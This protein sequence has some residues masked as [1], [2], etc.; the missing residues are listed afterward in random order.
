MTS[1]NRSDAAKKAAEYY[2]QQ[3]ANCPET[4][5]FNYGKIAENI[6]KGISNSLERLVMFTA[7][8]EWKVYK[9]DELDEDAQ[10]CLKATGLVN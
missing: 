4:D 3:S 9:L 5:S 2:Q 8:F 7:G 10:I 6:L 1:L